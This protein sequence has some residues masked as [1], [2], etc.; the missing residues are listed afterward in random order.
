MQ[1]IKEHFID[2]FCGT[3]EEGELFLEPIY[4][5]M[6]LELFSWIATE[7]SQLEPPVMEKIAD[8]L[9]PCP[10]C[11]SDPKIA[12][13]GNDK[14]NWIVMCFDCQRASVEMGV[15]EAVTKDDCIA[16]WNERI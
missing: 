10:F 12:S 1:E 2:K 6:P 13:L 16:M 14:E 4:L 8:G 11:G 9:L 5:T 15:K 3:T 7:V